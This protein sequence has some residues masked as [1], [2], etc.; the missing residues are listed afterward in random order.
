MKAKET[1]QQEVNRLLGAPILLSVGGKI[2][3]VQ[4]PTL[5]VLDLMSREWLKIP[6]LE[7]SDKM[8]NA[9]A[10]SIAKKAIVDNSRTIARSIAI[11][12]IGE[13]CFKPLGGVRIFLLSRKVL[14]NITHSE[15]RVAAEKL[16]GMAGIMDFIISMKLM[17]AN[18][19]TTPKN[20]IE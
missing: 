3:K 2:R 8:S 13:G 20:D 19:T 16:T 14:R 4:E 6:D 1:Q 15:C 12:I 17:S 9:E 7:F 5:G 10:L 11:G 18:T